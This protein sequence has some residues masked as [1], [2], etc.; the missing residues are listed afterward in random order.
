MPE[1]REEAGKRREGTVILTAS[2]EGNHIQLTIEDDGKGMSADV[3]RRKAVEKGLMDEE[4]AARMDNRECFNLI[5]M[6][7]FST[8]TEISDI[9][10]RG[11]GMDVVKTRIVQMNG[12]VEV[13]SAPGV[14]SRIIIK[15]PLTLAIMPT[16]MVKLSRQAFALP[17]A[18]VVEIL[19]LDLTKTNVVDGQLVVIVR[20]RALPLFY[21]GEWLVQ[22]Y[23]VS[24]EEKGGRG[25][26]V[27]VNAGGR[28]VGFVVDHLIGQEEV[29]IKRWAPSCKACPVWPERP[30]PVTA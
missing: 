26:V 13:E 9:S 4:A 22:Q 7:G 8:K 6:P 20:E 19:D 17:L 24:R 3:L 5:F 18:S 23:S 30:S 10:G 1:E 11:V 29:V 14:G 28:H 21:L 27:V 2:Q 12:T 25:H 15:L 16:L